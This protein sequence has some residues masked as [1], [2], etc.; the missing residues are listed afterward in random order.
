MAD[1]LKVRERYTEELTKLRA[2]EAKFDMEVAMN[3]AHRE[4]K[5]YDGLMAE[6]VKVDAKMDAIAAMESAVAHG[7]EKFEEYTLYKFDKKTWPIVL[8]NFPDAVEARRVVMDYRADLEEVKKKQGTEEWDASAARRLDFFQAGLA[9]SIDDLKAK[10]ANA[11]SP[12]QRELAKAKA[13]LERVN[14][15]LERASKP[16]RYQEEKNE[17][18]KFIEE[19]EDQL[20]TLEQLGDVQEADGQKKK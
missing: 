16:D 12:V 7:M 20:K 2:Q 14:E 6:M 5:K 18:D 9:R 15:R 1:A 13:K 17:L 8:K 11:A 19:L 10:T 4:R 3:K